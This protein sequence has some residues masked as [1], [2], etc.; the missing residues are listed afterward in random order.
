LLDLRWQSAT[1]LEAAVR[2]CF[3]AALAAH[4]G[5]PVVDDASALARAVALVDRRVRLSIEHRGSGSTADVVWCAPVTA[6]EAAALGARGAARY[7]VPSYRSAAL[8]RDAGVDAHAVAVTRPGFGAA[9]SVAP[10]ALTN[11][12]VV[13]REATAEAGI[14]PILA[15][16]G[17]LTVERM[18]AERADDAALARLAAAPLVVFA[19]DGDAWGLL[20]AAALA[21]GALVV[22]PARS[23]FLEIVPPDACVAVDDA[24]ALADA[25]RA[26]VAEPQ[27]LL[28]RG[29]R[30]AREMGRRSTSMHAGRRLREL[31]REQVYGAVDPRTLAMT[32][33]LAATLREREVIHG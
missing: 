16:L 17:A 3:R 5:A 29:P 21:G 33:A 18:P 8:L 9:T 12:I 23:A 32:P 7:W 26:I 27:A 22:A 6:A 13:A 10:R 11:A 1:P 4:A 31:G 25:V 28:D 2:R 14:T 19:D 30:A 15:A 20:G 24:A